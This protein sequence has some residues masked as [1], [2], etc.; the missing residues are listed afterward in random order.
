MKSVMV[1]IPLETQQQSEMIHLSTQIVPGS[2]FPLTNEALLFT[3]P[4]RCRSYP[5]RN[6]SKESFLDLSNSFRFRSQPEQKP[7][8]EQFL[9]YL[10]RR[11]KNNQF[12]A[13]GHQVVTAV[14]LHEPCVHIVLRIL[15]KKSELDLLHSLVVVIYFSK[16][17]TFL[18]KILF[19]LKIFNSRWNLK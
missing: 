15:K 6:E 18:D 4:Q 10:K 3:V 11:V 16:I 13:S 8:Q 5:I 17:F 2:F 9:F 7:T 19:A 14:G 1:S 12:G